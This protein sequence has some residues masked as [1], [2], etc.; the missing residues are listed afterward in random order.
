MTGCEGKKIE[1]VSDLGDEFCSRK[2]WLWGIVQSCYQQKKVLNEP[3]NEIFA[4]ISDWVHELFV[5]IIQAWIKYYH[6]IF[7]ESHLSVLFL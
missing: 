4:S 7:E 6:Y 2:H 1:I 5:L 3:K